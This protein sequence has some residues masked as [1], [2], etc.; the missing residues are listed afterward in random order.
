MIQ[1]IDH[2]AIAVADLD[3]AI[4]LWTKTTEA[5]VTLREVVADQKVEIVMLE[6]GTLRIELLSALSSDSPVAKFIASR[7]AGIHHLALEVDSAHNELQRMK[8]MGAQLIDSDARTGAEGTLVGFIHPRTFGGVLVEV[9]ERK[10]QG[11][12]GEQSTHS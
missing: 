4:D 9:V 7:G 12:S 1:G 6:V 3:T 11:E 10:P 2:I 5:R 8:L